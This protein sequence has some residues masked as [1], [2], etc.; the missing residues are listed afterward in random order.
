MTTYREVDAGLAKVIEYL[1][2]IENV[3]NETRTLKLHEV[4]YRAS[5]IIDKYPLVKEEYK[6]DDLFSWY[7]EDEYEFFTEWMEENNI[8]D[9]RKY[10]G[11][12]SSF[13]LTDIHGRNMGETI[14]E[15]MEHIAGYSIDF[16]DN[17]MMIPFTATDYYTEAELIDEYQEDMT[18]ISSGKFLEDIKKYLHDAVEIADYIDSFKKNQIAGFTEYIECKNDELEYQAEQDA[19]EEQAFMD[20]YIDAISDLTASIE[21]VIRTT[22][23]TLADAR[24]IVY[25][26]FEGIT[27]DGI[28]NTA[29]TA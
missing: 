22:G 4:S 12:T 24:R 3:W 15:L 28:Q 19:K 18:Y 10:I 2:S 23:C 8:E 21:E 9:C 7:C 25:K 6:E 17:G 26:S 20:K 29:E 14:T 13:Y 5:D 27:L 11:R 16:D 1:N